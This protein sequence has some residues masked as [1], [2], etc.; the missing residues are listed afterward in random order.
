MTDELAT[1]EP[2]EETEAPPTQPDE[3]E[4][5]ECVIC[6]RDPTLPELGGAFQLEVQQKDDD[7][8]VVG[9]RRPIVCKPCCGAIYAFLTELMSR[10][11]WAP[12]GMAALAV[13]DKRIV[14]PEEFD[15]DRAA[16]AASVIP[17]PFTHKK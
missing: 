5:V 3:Q 13:P 16:Q 14:T 8:N 10:G 6:G 12:P 9:I 11:V 7:G 17:F 15:K 1:E 4:V 2:Q